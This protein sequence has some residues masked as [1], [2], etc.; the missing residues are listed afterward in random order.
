MQQAVEDGIGKG[1]IADIVVPVLDGQLA[2]N[3]GGARA[4]AIVEHFEQIAAF[5][6]ADGGDR[7]VIDQ[8]QLCLGQGAQ[9]LS[10]AAIGVAQ[11]EIF[12]QSWGTQVQCR[13]ALTAGLV[14]GSSSQ[15]MMSRS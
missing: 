1:W 8:Q 14:G 7:E 11:T 3:D 10:E 4:H 2:G 15:T 12:E 13:Q 5:A 9:A 6:W